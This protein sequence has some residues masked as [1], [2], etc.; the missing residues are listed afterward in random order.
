[1]K[2]LAVLGFAGLSIPRKIEKGR[3]I[4]T[5]MTA[6][7]NFTTPNPPLATVNTN[8]NGLETAYIAAQGRWCR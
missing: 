3:F 8:I 2:S 4:V 7:A 6:N 1:M 5:S